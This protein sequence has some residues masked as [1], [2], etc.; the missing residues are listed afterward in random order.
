MGLFLV[1]SSVLG[2]IIIAGFILMQYLH[3]SGKN[4]IRLFK[5][6]VFIS[7]VIVLFSIA[8]LLLLDYFG[9]SIVTYYF[10]LELIG[11]CVYISIIFK[12]QEKISQSD[13]SAVAYLSV[14]TLLFQIIITVISGKYWTGIL[15]IVIV[16]PLIVYIFLTRDINNVKMA[17]SIVIPFY[18][19]LAYYA[20]EILLAFYSLGLIA[21]FILLCNES[22]RRRLQHFYST[23]RIKL[24]RTINEKLRF[25]NYS[26]IKQKVHFYIA[27]VE[28]TKL[29]Y[30]EE[31][32]PRLPMQ[33]QE[34]TFFQNFFM[35]KSVYGLE[36]AC[37][38]NF[39]FT[40]LIKTKT[41][42]EADDNGQA[43]LQRMTS[44][45]RG[46]DGKVKIVE[47]TKNI[48]YANDQKFFEIKSPKPPFT[49][50]F[51]L[52]KDFC[53]LYGHTDSEIRLYV[54]WK[55]AK[56]LKV[57]S[58][59]D[60][61]EMMETKDTQEKSS[62]YQ[63]WEGDLLRAKFLVS[64][65]ILEHT[66]NY[67]KERE[68]K[69]LEGMIKGLSLSSRNLKESAKRKK[70][71]EGCHA[72]ILK[73]NLY[74]GRNVTSNFL[75]FDITI[76]LP[77][78]K[79]FIL[80][81]PSKRPLD[82]SDVKPDDIMIG[83][84]I[85]D[86]VLKKVEAHV[87]IN[88]LAKSM[89]IIGSSGTGKTLYL[90]YI[91]NQIKKIS[92]IGVLYVNLAK[93]N[94]ENIYPADTYLKYGDKD[95][96]FPYYLLDVR[97]GKYREEVAEILAGSIG[98]KNVVVEN[99]I[100][101][102]DIFLDDGL[103]P[104]QVDGLFKSL[105][106]YFE[107][108]PYDA[109]FQTNITNAIEN[110]VRELFS[111]E[112]LIETLKPSEDPPKWFADWRNGKHVFIDLSACK[113]REKRL[114]TMLILQ[115]VRSLV[116]DKETDKLQG[117]IVMDEAH[118]ISLKA[119]GNN[120][121]DDEFI[122]RESLRKNLEDMVRENRYK[123]VCFAF[124]DQTADQMFDVVAKQPSLKL[125]F[126]QDLKSAEIYSNDLNEQKL[127]TRLKDREVFVIN[128]VQGLVYLVKTPDYVPSF[129]KTCQTIPI[130]L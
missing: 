59:R 17:L 8:E 111:K 102:L 12:Y 78:E 74:G 58:I 10:Y 26:R 82:N 18:L 117:I 41:E 110:R 95:L 123:G 118:Q 47:V 124:A 3:N 92:K 108:H 81:R 16:F 28:I 11:L 25:N 6:L 105:L 52:L 66:N 40:V 43:L 53:N 20:E 51:T 57:E 112:T 36:M 84:Y 89:I 100:N 76:D 19:I 45:Y 7:F 13:Y 65:K 32:D 96:T 104:P 79:T 55:K 29:A 38:N 125:L 107:L 120:V 97:T 64:Y 23:L 22:T 85:E 80:E 109:R 2:I 119:E 27:R 98:L 126:R 68:V 93:G 5:Y 62:Y 106:K 101:T 122:S 116:P 15:V 4:P 37:R 129:N 91:M 72:D 33:K 46:C 54:M 9:N 34:K 67:D 70:R 88:D 39:T 21:L 77:I 14:A 56:A 130:K 90:C 114:F 1:L 50:K 35:D 128:G 30:V 115:I 94:Q 48:L 87:S 60:R 86:G 71:S 83:N 44:M 103:D 49:E 69:K 31:L 73:G 113:K 61:I 127:L 121:D 75:D 63:M 42:K 99:L 24:E